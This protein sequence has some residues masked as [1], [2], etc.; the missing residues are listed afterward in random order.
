MKKN[1]PFYLKPAQWI[2]NR[3]AFTQEKQSLLGDFEEEFFEILASKGRIRASFWYWNQVLVSLIPFLFNKS[4]WS[5]TMLLNYFKTAYRNLL[6]FKAYA[7]INILGLAIGIGATILILIYIQFEFSYDTFHSQGD[8]IYRI[9][10]VHTKEGKFESDSHI[11][12]PPI[13]ADMKSEFPEVEDF[14]RMS[15]FKTAY[16]THNNTS[17]KIHRI[18]YASSSFFKFFS[19]NLLAGNPKNILTDPYSI[20]LTKKTAVQLFGDKNPVGQL[21]SIN[22]KNLYR[23]NGVVQNPPANSHLQFNMLISFSSLYEN[24]RLYLDWNGG[25]QYITYVKLYKNV[26]P[27][28]V[29]G[30]FPDFMWKHINELYS[31]YGSKLIPYLQ[32]LDDIHIHHTSSR[33]L[34][35]IY[36][37]LAIAL[38]ILIIACIN[39][40]NLTTARAVKRAKEVGLRKVLGAGKKN[41]IKQFLTESTLVSFLSLILAIGLVQLLSPLYR[42]FLNRDLNFIKM[43]DPNSLLGLF[44]LIIIVGIIAGSYP[45]FYLS[46][47]HPV[48]TLKGSLAPGRGKEQFR[49]FLVIF[50]FSISIILI[51]STILIN[52]QILYMKNMDL[53]FNTSNMLVIPLEGDGVQSRANI[54]K[55]DL[56]KIPTVLSITASSDVPHNGFT[57]N[58]YIPEGLKYSTMI[59][60]V[61]VDRDF[62][63]TFDIKIVKGRNFSMAFPSDKKAYLINETLAK[64]LNWENPIG[65]TIYRNDNRSV[66]GMVRDFKFSSLHKKIGPLI[67]TNQP[68]GGKFSYISIKINPTKISATLTSIRESWQKV[69]PSLP[70][71]FW[72]LDE[73]VNSLYRSEERF[74]EIFLTFSCLAIFIAMM[75]LFSLASFSVEQRAKEI[76]I[77]KVLGASKHNI[78]LIFSKKFIWLILLANLIAGPI[79][80]YL[81]DT[82]LKNF[83]FKQPINLWIFI[84]TFFGIIIV[85]LMSITFQLYRAIQKNPVDELKYE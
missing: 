67:I 62:L 44:L 83:A 53:G 50:Q 47:F 39:F 38:F 34:I 8:R 3:T 41:L 9:S 75:G 73:S 65:K 29:E 64:Q 57:S 37:F 66:I 13:G 85:S 42:Q 17:L 60:V 30:K 20:V 49:N 4:Y 22:Q 52:N 19:F 25:N 16:V 51:I 11:F 71:D 69:A 36:V 31:K 1:F 76:G 84:Y 56:G 55:E 70:L 58:G 2:L 72:F 21:I 74:M 61:D 81:M 78:F 77:R 59:H 28:I 15:N 68:D 10:V 6:R 63:K 27:E 48:R 40:I 79:T 80:I 26:T 46:S 54:L 32:P 23:V 33:I 14:L 35:K 5:L 24:P 45:A 82:W 43:I 18:R 12:T 7:V